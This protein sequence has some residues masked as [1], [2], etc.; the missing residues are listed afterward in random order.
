MRGVRLVAFLAAL[1]F[2][3]LCA[4]ESLAVGPV[5]ARLVAESTSIRPGTPFLVAVAFQMGPGWHIYWSNPGDTG[6]PTTI[7]WDLPN[8]FHAS[9]VMW[10]APH[11]FISQG[12][13][14]YGYEREVSLLTRITPPAKSAA[15]G[16]D[17]SR[18]RELACLPDRMHSGEGGPF[19]FAAGWPGRPHCGQALGVASEGSGFHGSHRSPRD[20][21]QLHDAGRP[22]TASR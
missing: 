17:L 4:A 8:G 5:K 6:L 7:A 9:S 11:R 19:P 12:L 3:M 13:A 14:S 22:D 16:R 18:A 20:A 15:G 21:V 1:F 2:P 10:P